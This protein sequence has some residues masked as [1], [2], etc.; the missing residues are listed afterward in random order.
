MGSW[1]NVKL[2][3]SAPGVLIYIHSFFRRG[4][5]RGLCTTKVHFVFKGPYIGQLFWQIC[6]LSTLI[7]KFEWSTSRSSRFCLQL[8]GQICYSSSL[9]AL[10]DV[11]SDWMAAI[12]SL[13]ILS[14]FLY[15]KIVCNPFTSTFTYR[16][17]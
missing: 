15:K 2:C 6:P 7:W 17:A 10:R 9:K 14:L 5:N 4:G 8:Y 13:L 12:L 16:Q 11:V 1:K 3:K